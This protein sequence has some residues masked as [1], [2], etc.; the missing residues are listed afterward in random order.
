MSPSK[1]STKE[2]LL[3]AALE[4]FIDQGIAATTTKAIAERAEVNE[5]TL[6]RQFGNKNGLLLAILT[7]V[8]I[9]PDA[10][11]KDAS[12]AETLTRYS[13]Q[14]LQTLDRLQKFVHSL[15]GEA[16][17]LPLENRQALH[18]TLHQVNQ[19]LAQSVASAIDQS[20][21]HSQ[22]SPEV[23]ASL[24]HS[25]LLG[26]SLLQTTSDHPSAWKTPEDFVVTVTQLLVSG[27]IKEYRIPVTSDPS[28]LGEAHRAI[29]D[30]PASLVRNI[31]KRAQKLGRQPYAFA[32]T[33]FA[34]GLSPEEILHLNR[35]HYIAD[36]DQHLLQINQGH[37]RQVPL[38]QWIAGKR[39][40]GDHTNPL[41][42]WLKSR[43]D[44]HHAIFLDEH[45]Q[46]MIAIAQ[47]EDFWHSMTTDLVTAQ[48]SAP[49]MVQAQQTWCVEMLTK[50]MEAEQL[51]LLSGL[52]LSELQP[53]QQRV[54]EKM[55]IEQAIKL[56][57]V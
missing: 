42:Q 6:F 38:N 34:A 20:Q 40:G 21:Q 13:Q 11:P 33:L 14:R 3:T 56:D 8:V 26:Y 47:L 29:H 53:F 39:Y 51:S 54:S 2:R 16:S 5:V 50:G 57:R 4:L 30:L 45:L 41:Y 18:Q 55:A 19:Q 46:P 15:I 25:L 24:L 1:P 12:F 22:F 7:E 9:A 52:T 32:Y 23:L 48:G 44:E 36:P 27:A 37:V 31:L 17:Q 35:T 49:T 28:G 10:V 43:K